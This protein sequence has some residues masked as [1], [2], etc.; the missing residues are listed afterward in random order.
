VDN[1]FAQAVRLEALAEK[2]LRPKLG[3]KPSQQVTQF[4][5]VRLPSLDIR[6]IPRKILVAK[7]QEQSPILSKKPR[8]EVIA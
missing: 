2:K 8:K 3:R 1:D 6:M 7:E 4:P 5:S